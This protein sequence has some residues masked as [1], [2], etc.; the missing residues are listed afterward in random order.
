M[1]RL[2]SFFLFLFV[3]VPATLFGA[4]K[5]LA[6]TPPM[7][8]NSWDSYGRTIDEQQVRATADWMATNLKRYGWEYVV[9]D[10]G[11]YVLNPKDDPKTYKF[12]LSADGRFVPDEA[13]YPSSR[14]GAGL[15]PVADYIHSLG[16]KFGIHILRGIPRQ[17]VRENG[18]IAG[19]SFHAADAANQQDVCPWNE[20][21][22]G[23]ND[24]AA[25]QAYYDSIA[26][27]YAGWGVD[28]VKVDCIADHPYKPEEIRM[29][30]QALDKTGR[31]IIVSLSPGPTA[32]EHADYVARYSEMWRISDDYWDHWGP[33]PGHEWSMS[34]HDQFANAAKWMSVRRVPGHWP[35]ADMLPL[36][37]FPQ[38]GAGDPRRTRLTPDEQ[39]SMMT[40]WAMFRSPLMMGGDLLTT[41]KATT[42]LLTNTDIIAIDQHSRDNRAIITKPD[43]AVWTARP[44]GGDDYFLAVFN[45]ADA[46][47][48]LSFAW[49][50]LG[51][52][53]GRY[54]ATDLWSKDKQ[55]GLSSFNLKDLRPHACVVVRLSK[56]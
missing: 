23:L 20:Y 46:P 44:E 49:K 16:L 52:E 55:K 13:R 51:I 26:K 41:D 35:D 37:N 9:I 36:G 53:E 31:D 3:A 30:R 2:C 17:F 40:L 18:T 5:S 29:L 33:W 47:Q 50:E 4:D 25:A 19:S 56:K 54:N 12:A 7:G 43:L 32:T 28:F 39:V 24:N 8:W 14:N 22:Y 48:Q 11:W 27:L 21:N 38:P 15:K 10:E 45:L 1:N 42:R 6:P 34:L